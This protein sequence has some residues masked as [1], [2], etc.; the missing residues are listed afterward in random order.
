VEKLRLACVLVLL[1]ATSAMAEDKVYVTKQWYGA[2]E[3]RNMEQAIVY[4]YNDDT[5]ALKKMVDEKKVGIFHEG[6]EVFITE[7][8]TNKNGNNLIHIRKIGT[9]I[10]IWTHMAAVACR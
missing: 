4:L 9:A 7:R 5:A 3:L 6:T 2:L 10:E 1:A 8:Y